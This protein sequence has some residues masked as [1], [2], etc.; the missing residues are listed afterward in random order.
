MLVVPGQWPAP[1]EVP[2]GL[3]SRPETSEATASFYSAGRQITFK[4]LEPELNK[5]YI[6]KL[7]YK[8]KFWS[9]L[10]RFSAKVGHGTV[11]NGPGLNKAA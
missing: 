4:L 9:I 2:G 11:T 8:F 5:S 7:N 6:S 3:K 1:P 10:G